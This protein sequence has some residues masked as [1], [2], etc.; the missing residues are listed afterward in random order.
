MRREQHRSVDASLAALIVGKWQEPAPYTAVLRFD[1][2]GTVTVA[3]FEAELDTKPLASGTWALTGSQLT[4][5]NT[6]GVCSTPVSNQTGVYDIVVTAT[7]L[8]FSM[9]NDPCPQRN[10]IDGETWKKLQ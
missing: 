7:T 2:S 3:N 6:S 5:V 1:A 9:Q 10:V 4:F 8:S